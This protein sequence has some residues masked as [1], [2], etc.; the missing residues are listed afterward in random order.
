[1]YG[2]VNGHVYGVWPTF[3]FSKSVSVSLSGSKP[4][5]A[6]TQWLAATSV[7]MAAIP[8][9]I[10]TEPQWN[11]ETHDPRIPLS[12]AYN[13]PITYT[14][15]ILIYIPVRSAGGGLTHYN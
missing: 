5:V 3:T 1:V 13:L 11:P 10:A 12:L 8:M 7:M 14:Q 15:S 2:Y 9:A 4:A 6:P